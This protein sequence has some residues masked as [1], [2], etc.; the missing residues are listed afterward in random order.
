MRLFIAGLR[1]FLVRQ[2]PF[3]L[4]QNHKFKVLVSRAIKVFDIAAVL[5]VDTGQT[6]TRAIDF[7]KLDIVRKG[8]LDQLVVGTIQVGE[9]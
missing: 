7:H 1:V 9:E 2:G 3:A 5:Q 8:Q 6:I 4:A